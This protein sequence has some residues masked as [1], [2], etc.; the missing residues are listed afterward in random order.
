MAV[1]SQ[2]G[3]MPFP[4][5]QR[6]TSTPQSEALSIPPQVWVWFTVVTPEAQ[7]VGSQRRLGP[8][9]SPERDQGSCPSS[10]TFPS[11]RAGRGV[12]G[13]CALSTAGTKV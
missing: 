2:A 13:Q 11:A 7:S 12:D 8:R 1:R 6:Q 5:P 4:H 9:R 3:Q 10:T